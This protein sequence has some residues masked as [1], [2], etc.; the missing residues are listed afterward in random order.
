MAR[1]LTMASNPAASTV[2]KYVGADC[3]PGRSRR[4]R[5]RDRPR[6]RRPAGR[7]RGQVEVAG[8]VV[9]GAGRDDA[10]RGSRCRRRAWTREVHHAVAADHHQ[11]ST[12]SATHWRARSSASSAS[13]PEV[14]HDRARRPAAA[15]APV[16]D[17]A[18]LALAGRGVRQQGD[19]ARRHARRLP[20][21]RARRLVPNRMFSRQVSPFGPKPQSVRAVG[22]DAEPDG[23]RPCGAAIR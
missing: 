11:A 2:T 20:G 9:A 1:S 6:R 4:V 8:H 21:V 7:L 15:A 22:T 19:L 17:P 16:A 5:A 10:E 13:R 23:V 18:A 3:A 14:A 12:P